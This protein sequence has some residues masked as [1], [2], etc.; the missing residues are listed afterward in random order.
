ML[1]QIH[2]S[3]QTNNYD[4]RLDGLKKAL[5]LFFALN[6]QNYSRYGSIYVNIL[7]QLEEIFPGCK[8]LLVKKALLVQSQDRYPLRTNIDQC[9]EQTINRDA[10]TSE[11]ITFFVSDSNSI[12]K[13]TLNRPYQAQNTEAFYNLVDLSHTNDKYKASRPSQIL[14]PPR[15]M[16]KTS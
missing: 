4:L 12:L 7:S 3:V 2:Y 1:H 15:S 13:W 6:K 8:D 9:G 16:S 5:P 11:G 14:K 10:K